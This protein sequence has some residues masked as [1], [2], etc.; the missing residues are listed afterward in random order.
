MAYIYHYISIIYYMF[1][2]HN[3]TAHA[4]YQM[5][6][7]CARAAVRV[8]RQGCERGIVRGGGLLGGECWVKIKIVCVH[9]KKKQKKKT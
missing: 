8:Q 2:N 7:E 3:A 6:V 5:E 4:K 1:I 9:E